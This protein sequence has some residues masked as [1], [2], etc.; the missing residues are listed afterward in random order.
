MLKN[1][2][3]AIFSVTAFALTFSVLPAN[4]L[5]GT[6]KLEDAT[7]ADINQ[8]FDDG[9]LTSAQLTQL[10][11]NRI[12]AYDKQGPNINSIITINPKALETAAALDLERQTKGAR[13][14]LHGIPVLLKDNYDTSDLPTTAG[15]LALADF[16]PPNDAFQ[17]KKLRDAG[18]IILGKTNM[19]EFAL[20]VTTLSSLGGQTLNPYALDRVPGGSS[21]GS[22]TA[23]AANFATLGTATDTAISIRGPASINNLVGIRPTIGLT[24]RNGIIPLLSTQDTGG[25]IARNVTDA[26]YMLD[27][28][29]G[30][31]PLDPVTANS[32]GKIPTSYTN[33]LNP[34]GLKGKRIGVIRELVEADMAKNPADPDVLGLTNAAIEDMKAKGADVFDV[35]IPNLDFFVRANPF[36]DSGYEYRTKF[37]INNYLASLGDKA[38]YKSL[39]ELLDS[40]K[41]LPTDSVEGYLRFVD[42]TTLTPDQ[43]PNYQ[44]YLQNKAELKTTLQNVI[45]EQKLDAFL[46]PTMTLKPSLIGALYPGG[47]PGN[48][49]LSSFTGFPAMVV[50]AGFTPDGLPVGVELLG[51]EFSEPTLISLAYSY[52]QATKYRR[53]PN[54]T[55]ALTGEVFERKSVPEPNSFIGILMLG[56]LGVARFSKRAAST[57][58]H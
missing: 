9:S 34:D 6:F 50:P 5:A 21:G 7:I 54:S 8:A 58:P 28:L 16:I 23:I 15:S 31:D 13:S 27:V 12:N 48:S 33:F 45:N 46:Y 41:V 17:T 30:Y 49:L 22:G 40:G 38:P 2:T 4:V 57:R 39:T 53:L 14:P 10:Y 47:Y 36:A 44:L 11:L 52:E 35:K 32:I 26:A 42:Q 29:A 3:Q 55:P 25:P 20:D 56:F 43:N 51:S 18:A 37:D 24:S 19:H 1:F